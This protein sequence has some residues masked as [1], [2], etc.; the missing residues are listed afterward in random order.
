MQFEQ[1]GNAFADFG[2]MFDTFNELTVSSNSSQSG[3][4]EI[5]SLAS[6]KYTF[7]VKGNGGFASKPQDAPIGQLQQQSF[8]DL[9]PDTKNNALLYQELEPSLASNAY[10][11]SKLEARSRVPSM[12]SPA[13][14]SPSICSVYGTGTHSS[15]LSFPELNHAMPP[16]V[17]AAVDPKVCYI[18]HCH[19]FTKTFSTYFTFFIA[20]R[21]TPLSNASAA[22]NDATR[23]AN[24]E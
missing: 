9:A 10:N 1:L 7:S 11:V 17:S 21:K 18:L 19:A 2:L 24:D 20:T 14:V 4:T 12:T 13:S 23:A 22:E 15:S 8:F 5:E 16:P 3:E 6:P